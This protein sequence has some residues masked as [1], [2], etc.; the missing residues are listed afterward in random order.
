M[1]NLDSVKNGIVRVYGNAYAK[2]K[3][4]IIE[5]NKASCNRIV[6]D[7]YTVIPQATYIGGTPYYEHLF[8][9]FVVPTVLVDTFVRF[10]DYLLYR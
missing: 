7:C 4:I 5:A 10:I 6:R 1:E 9:R 8:M 2:E 3:T